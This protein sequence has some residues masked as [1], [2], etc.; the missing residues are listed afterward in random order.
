MKNIKEFVFSQKTIVMICFA[1]V[2]LGNHQVQT[3]AWNDWTFYAC[4]DITGAMI[5]IVVLTC[6][7]IS[8]LKEHPVPYIV[9]ACLNVVFCPVFIII[10]MRSGNFFAQELLVISLGIFLLG[11]CYIYLFFAFR[12]KQYPRVY[13]PLL[14]LWIVMMIWMIFFRSYN[15]W[16]IPYLGMFLALYLMPKTSVQRKNI[17]HGLFNGLIL[18]YMLNQ[19]FSLL[20]RPYDIL[21]YIGN[22]SN[23]N[24][25]CAFLC[26]CLG[27]IM[28]RFLIAVK[29]KE[30]AVVKV[31]LAI[32]ALADYSFI[33]M[34]VCRSGMLS[35]FIFTVVFAAALCNITGKKIFIRTGL[36]L[37]VLIVISLPVTYAAVRYI[38]LTN[39]YVKYYWWD[40]PQSH[41]V[42]REDKRTSDKYI[43]FDE[44]LD[45]LVGRVGL[46]V[47]ETA[48]ALQQPEE[49]EESENTAGSDNAVGS[50]INVRY[51]IH[52][53]YLTHLSWHGVPK[54]EQGFY[55][56][57]DHYVQDTHNI[58]LDYGINFGGPAMVMYAALM[59][60]AI[61]RSLIRARKEKNV[62]LWAAA[63]FLVMPVSFGFFEFF[64][65]AG[66]VYTI[67]SYFCF[68]EALSLK[69]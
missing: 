2:A 29:E 20:F 27:G 5:A 6:A 54:E 26:I 38:P 8:A 35:T 55:L 69:E 23:P 19:A 49:T 10:G 50:T 64:W 36:I 66:T 34:T 28:G 31:F 45:V 62:N 16:P 17:C 37:A 11:V 41:S 56:T 1:I 21:R 51:T 63:I 57:E 67:I 7:K 40:G 24:H 25:N 33:L 52:K 58:F 12:A 30:K 22:Y 68:D 9:W 13:K 65:G 44:V 60:W 15:I 3:A 39:P 59:I 4:R 42:T 32:L 53:W 47:S 46:T 14:V 48:D 61:A 18:A 43:G